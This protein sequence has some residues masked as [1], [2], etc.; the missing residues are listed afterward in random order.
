VGKT[1]WKTIQGP[2]IAALLRLELSD[3]MNARFRRPL[4]AIGL[5][6]SGNPGADR[7]PRSQTGRERTA[8]A[9]AADRRAVGC[10]KNGARKNGRTS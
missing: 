4:I 5:A 7:T 10:R 2:K 1:L 8:V 3:H 6:P 9:R